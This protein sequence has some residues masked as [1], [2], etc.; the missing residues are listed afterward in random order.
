LEIL[1]FL[2]VSIRSSNCL[3]FS[4]AMVCPIRLHRASRGGS[5]IAA[6]D[7]AKVEPINAMSRWRIFILVF[8][9]QK[10][11]VDSGS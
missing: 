10:S 3:A 4:V 9:W 8:T 7:Q 6:A 1:P 5:A 2:P 11:R